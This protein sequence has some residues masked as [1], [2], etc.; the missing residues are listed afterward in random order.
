MNKLLLDIPASLETDRLMLRSYSAGDGQMLFDA[1]IRNID[2]LSRFESGNILMNLESVEHAEI[3]ARQ[4]AVDW[5]A[6]NCFFIGIFDKTSRAW[7]GQIY[8]GPTSWRLPEF[9]I[10]F[11]ADKEFEGKGYMA[12]AVN[13]VLTMLFDVMGAHRIKSD[14]NELNIRSAKL[15][16]RCGFKREGHLRQNRR[17]PDGSF[18]G[19]F[20]YGMLAQD[21]RERM[22]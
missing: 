11:A 22:Q 9:T 10:G 5:A 17:N 6:R 12:E 20:L 19:D 18:H 14:C 7:V 21:F 16:E 3:T 8:V 1:G 4:L 13:S 15:L 2:H